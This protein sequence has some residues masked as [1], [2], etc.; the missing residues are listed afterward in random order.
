[1]VQHIFTQLYLTIYPFWKRD[2]QLL[3][4]LLKL[5]V[6]RKIFSGEEDPKGK[7]WKNMRGGIWRNS[8]PPIYRRFLEELLV[9]R[10]QKTHSTSQRQGQFCQVD[11][12]AAM[13]SSWNLSQGWNVKSRPR[14]EDLMYKMQVRQPERHDECNLSQGSAIYHNGITG[15]KQNRVVDR[16]TG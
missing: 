9:W 3:L 6:E 8:L 1:M 12:K 11:F 5:P 4:L 7:Q 16:Q 10:F 13:V 15:N 2:I 14:R